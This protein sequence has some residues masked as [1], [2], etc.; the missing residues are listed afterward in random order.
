[1][2]DVF[3]NQIYRISPYS[4][5]DYAKNIEIAKHYKKESFF[6]T[7]KYKNYFTSSGRE[8]IKLYLESLS[9]KKDDEVTILTS[10][11]SFY[12]SSC[13]TNVIESI[14]KWNRVLSNKTKCILV[15]HEF[16]KY[17]ENVKELKKYNL[18]I[19][20]D[21]AHTFTSL[22][23]KDL[24]VG[25]AAIF[26]LSKFLPTN[27]G[28]ILLSKKSIKFKSINKH[29]SIYKYYEKDLIAFYEKRKII[30]KYYIK[31]IKKLGFK[32]FFDF[33]PYEVP[34]A[35]IFTIDK[36]ENTLQKLKGYLQSNYIEC[37][38]FYGENAFFVPS[39]HN[40]KESDVDY[41]LKHIKR[42]LNNETV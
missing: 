6:I 10:S 23:Y 31:E 4:T 38:V 24:I 22:I 37:S 35:F 29:E 34:G 17:F 15:I 14:C 9:L 1:M 33:R 2:N 3:Y 30:Q 11:S 25:D 42:F 16:G 18:P 19:I 8:A 36:D 27:N 28:G 12:I 41:I 32:S 40:L 7:E 20:E 39:H 5:S 21:F 26:S 13:V